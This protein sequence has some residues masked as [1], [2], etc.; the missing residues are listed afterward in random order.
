MMQSG[1]SRSTKVGL[2]TAIM[3]HT[4][5]D[6]TAIISAVLEDTLD[7][8]PAD[9]ATLSATLGTAVYAHADEAV[10]AAAAT[11]STAVSP[12]PP[13]SPVLQKKRKV[14]KRTKGPGTG[15]KYSKFVGL[16]S[17]TLSGLC[18]DADDVEVEP[19]VKN[20]KADSKS[21]PTFHK[22]N[23]ELPGKITYRELV[24]MIAK[25]FDTEEVEIRG[26]PP[27]ENGHGS[28]AYFPTAGVAWGLLGKEAQGELAALAP[29]P[30][31][32]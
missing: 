27:G 3:T 17:A 6:Y 30:K 10:K 5:S 18:A 22:L 12:S 16:T 24:E 2:V 7:L 23:L 13:S 8:D 1:F 20:F 4:L 11:A 9:L 28:K 26:K 32:K 19:S 14:T 25:A 31:G 15:N 21:L 29:P